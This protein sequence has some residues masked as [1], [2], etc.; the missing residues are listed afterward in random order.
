MA[1]DTEFQQPVW[2]LL[3]TGP[4]AIS[5]ACRSCFLDVL[6]FLVIAKTMI[7]MTIIVIANPAAE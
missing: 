4:P 2:L 1:P 5:L 6:G 3:V 7:Q